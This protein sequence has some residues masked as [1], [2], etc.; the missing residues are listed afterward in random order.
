MKINI[1]T[2]MEV[3]QKK[4]LDAFREIPTLKHSYEVI[5][6]GIGRE[7]TAKGFLKNTESDLCILIGF[8]AIVG[9]E[10]TMPA[11]LKKGESVEVVASSLFG[12]E[13]EVFEN[14]KLRLTS[15]KTHLPCLTS[16]T[17]DK[18]VKT[19]NIPVGTLINMEDYTFMCLKRPQDFIIRVISDFLPHKE[20]IDFFK[21]IEDI[22]FNKVVEVL[23][24]I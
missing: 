20:E 17:S 19:T 14:G 24:N 12:Y 7:N 21:V 10:K 23:E 3:E 2:P 15:S 9:K 13:G 4:I 16:L 8:T 6:T 1:L 18:F 11:E 22:K 5:K